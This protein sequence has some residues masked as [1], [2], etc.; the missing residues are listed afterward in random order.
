MKKMIFIIISVLFL[1]VFIIGI[2]FTILFPKNSNKIEF[3]FKKE[4]NNQIVT[5]DNLIY[6]KYAKDNKL[7]QV[8]GN[9]KYPDMNDNFHILIRYSDTLI[10][11][12]LYILED[13]NIACEIKNPISIH[14][15]KYHIANELIT[16][17]QEGH[18]WKNNKDSNS[19]QVNNLNVQFNAVN[20]F[21][22]PVKVK[23]LNDPYIKLKPAYLIEK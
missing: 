6:R 2:T 18:W 8:W 13:D 21:K 23:N 17:K 15:T 10:T 12:I 11:K 5:F 9:Y 4:A 14:I 20:H 3:V 16:K 1:L 19:N 22:K 7:V